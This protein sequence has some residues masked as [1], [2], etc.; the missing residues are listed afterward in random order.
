MSSAASRECSGFPDMSMNIARTGAFTSTRRCRTNAMY[1]RSSSNAAA[2]AHVCHTPVRRS[3]IGYIFLQKKRKNYAIGVRSSSQ[4]MPANIDALPSAHV[5]FFFSGIRTPPLP[6]VQDSGLA[7]PLF[8]A[9]HVSASSDSRVT[10]LGRWCTGVES[11]GTMQSSPVFRNCSSFEQYN[12]VPVSSSLGRSSLKIVLAEPHDSGSTF[13]FFRAGC[14]LG[15]SKRT[16]AFF[17]RRTGTV[18]IRSL[19]FG[20]TGAT[21]SSSF[22]SVNESESSPLALV[23]TISSPSQHSSS[24]SVFFLSFNFPNT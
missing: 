20:L 10:T 16:R 7:T 9:S 11:H 23:Y 18:L 3:S 8:A 24:S 5:R 6:A 22:L 21:T 2:C 19:A 4:T 17:P 14:N 12:Y 13:L 15:H 1:D